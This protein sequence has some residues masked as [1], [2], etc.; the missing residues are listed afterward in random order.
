MGRLF[1]FALYTGQYHTQSL[2]VVLNFCIFQSLLL[3]FVTLNWKY[4]AGRSIQESS[5][6]GYFFS[7]IVDDVNS[8]L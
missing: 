5:L 1:Y 4:L 6:S 3:P 2:P 7:E 8:K